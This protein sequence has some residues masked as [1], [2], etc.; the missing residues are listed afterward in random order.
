MSVP[1][2]I[3]QLLIGAAGAGGGGY[4]PIPSTNPMFDTQLA[5]LENKF[6][7][8]APVD[9]PPARFFYFLDPARKNA[10]AW[11]PRDGILGEVSTVVLKSHDRFHHR[12]GFEHRWWRRRRGRRPG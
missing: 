5:P 10:V 1:G 12:W 2:S 6:K 4:Q 9:C 8:S 7:F 3:N 11:D